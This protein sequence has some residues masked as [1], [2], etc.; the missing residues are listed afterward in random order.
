MR[1]KVPLEK[2]GQAR[3]TPEVKSVDWKRPMVGFLVSML[4][5]I[6][7]VST[8]L[9]PDRASAAAGRGTAA[10]TTTPMTSMSM[11]LG[12]DPAGSEST[13]T[14]AAA[15]TQETQ[16][17]QT[18]QI[19]PETTLPYDPPVTD[20]PDGGNQQ[21]L[22]DLLNVNDNNGTLDLVLLITILSLAPS[23]VIM[24][25]CFT[26]LI[27]VF[28]LLRNAIGVQATPPN[29]VLVGLALF[30]TLFI[31]QPTISKMN[32]VAYKPY[33][34][35][36][37]TTVEACTAASQPLKE[38]MLLNTSNES[39]S[40]FLELSASSQPEEYQVTM[41]TGTN[42]EIAAALPLTVVVPSFIISE[43]KT[44]FTAG[45][46]L[47]LPFLIIDIVVSSTL[48]SLGMIMLPPAM[49]SLP[50]KILLFILVNGWQLLVG[51]L[52]RGFNTFT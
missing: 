32:E 38:F 35:G 7:C 39:L 20:T 37:L 27:I 2:G 12:N 6:L 45:F 8:V 50:F 5:I 16:T 28:S 25:T 40:F 34:A 29:Q 4:A 13:G 49:I 51:S 26:R 46:Y 1:G 31:M 14:G 33:K 15:Q 42:E 22:L 36:E 52:V 41:P 3:G 43:I 9:Q 11:R 24:M 18:S 23:I 21:G 17:A 48:M 47:F 30:L 44:G 19:L 10:A